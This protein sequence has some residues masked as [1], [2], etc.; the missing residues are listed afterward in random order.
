MTNPVNF[1]FDQWK[2]VCEPGDYVF[3]SSFDRNKKRWF[4]APFPFDNTTKR[5][6]RDWLRQNP[7]KEKDIYWCP[8]PFSDAKRDE[9][10]TKPV[11]MFWSDIDDGSIDKVKPSVL[12]ESSPGRHHGL[13]YIDSTLEADEAGDISRTLTHY[14]G[15][16][17]GGW[18]CTQV[19]RI[20]GTYN[21]KYDDKPEVKLLSNNKKEYD[22]NRLAKKISY[23]PGEHSVEKLELEEA[24][25][26][27]TVERLSRDKKL[28]KVIEAT[29]MDADGYDRSEMIFKLS[30]QLAE[31]GVEP[32]DIYTIM[33]NS[34]F[35]KYAGKLGEKSNLTRDISK[36]VDKVG[37]NSQVSVK[38][39]KK[40]KEHEKKREESENGTRFRV[41][42][43]HTM[44]TTP[45]PKISWMVK[46][47]WQASSFG[48]VAGEPKSFKSVIAMDIGISVASGKP[49]M[50]KHPVTQQGGVL[51]IDN[52]N[53]EGIMYD[54][55]QKMASAK[56]IKRDIPFYL[57]PVQS[58]KLDDE[59]DQVDLWKLV[60]DLKPVLVIIDPLYRSTNGD[61][62]S[63][64]DM[65]VITDFL[66]DM[67]TELG[68]GVMVV[69]HSSK[70]S[71]SK[72]GGN[73]VYGTTFLHGWGESNLYLQSEANLDE[74][75]GTIIMER[76]FRGAGL[77]NKLEAQINIGDMGERIY[78]TK[79]G[80][81]YAEA[82]VKRVKPE[83]VQKEII[84]A[85]EIKGSLKLPALMKQV[86]VTDK[87]LDEALQG[88]VNDGKVTKTKEGVT[89]VHG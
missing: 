63:Q 14:I 7:P 18:D 64:E 28:A 79:I 3:L 30:C 29:Q 11:N 60:E 44:A 56:R 53:G 25:Y 26:E 80:E 34:D 55:Y 46:D 23:V 1:L 74:G 31:R 4:D 70:G 36:A 42:D 82:D 86:G 89:L 68:V 75:W 48:L 16:D 59:D 45:P 54:R 21:H 71:D 78:E 77:R 62:S 72:R 33:K 87:Q 81:Y 17:P 27:E 83:T 10:Y 47:I 52:E 15:A 35:N 51:Y 84:A 22:V 67:H 37:K 13:W 85:L 88:L 41:V 50:N 24:D 9:Q 19:L 5:R 2:R 61:I 39:S 20:P 32:D 8:A 49:F 69:H 76:E 38:E 12:W 65:G 6:V 58:L 43:A 57:V 66:S 40:K 73:R